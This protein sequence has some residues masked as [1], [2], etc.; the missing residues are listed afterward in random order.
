MVAV[1][2]AAQPLRPCR[3]GVLGR[4]SHRTLPPMAR[5]GILLSGAGST[6]ANLAQAIDEGTLP[7]TIAVV[8]SSRA[9]AGGCAIAR[10]RGHALAVAQEPAAVTAALTAHAVDWV[11]MCGWLRYWDPPERWALRTLNIHPSL[12]PAFGGRGMYGVR[13][14]EAVLANG[15]KLTGCTVHLVTGDY[16]SGPIL[17]QRA[18]PVR[19]QDTPASLQARVQAAE[20]ALYPRVIAALLRA[21]PRRAAH[22]WW[23]DLPDAGEGA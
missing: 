17:A 9:D 19:E 13:V 11:V 21:P 7:A 1:G 16:D 8:V 4:P 15:C 10:R 20:A 6:Y 5:L 18:V 23:V 2:E 12:L 14:H 22:G 3:Q